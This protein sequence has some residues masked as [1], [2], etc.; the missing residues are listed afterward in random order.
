MI[1][2]YLIFAH[3]LADF[4]FQPTKLIEWKTRNFLGILVHVIIFFTVAATVLYPYLSNAIVWFVLLGISAVHFITDQIKI[5]T[6]IRTTSYSMPFILDQAV[7]LLSLIFGSV[8]IQ[9]YIVPV[10]YIDL[11]ILLGAF[12]GIYC[13][14][15]FFIYFLQKSSS[16]K[17]Q[18]IKV[19]TFS[20]IYLFYCLAAFLF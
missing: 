8:I 4:I 6:S 13:L 20:L 5:K 15:V 12:V 16:R 2:A 11:N 19:G 10:N 17:M 14:Y 9:R 3:L 7:H 1:T 18:H